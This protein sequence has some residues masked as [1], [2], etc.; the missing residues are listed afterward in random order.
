LKNNAL[1]DAAKKARLFDDLRRV[2]AVMPA[3]A[4]LIDV[5]ATYVSITPPAD[6]TRAN[7]E[8][9]VIACLRDALHSVIS[10]NGKIDPSRDA[11]KKFITALFHQAT[12]LLDMSVCVPDTDEEPGH[13]WVPFA[14]SLADYLDRFPSAQI[15]DTPCPQR[16]YIDD[17]LARVMVA[18]RVLPIS[19]ASVLS[20]PATRATSTTSSATDEAAE[21]A[22]L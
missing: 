12:K 7:S 15:V 2:L 11:E 9:L 13:C 21:A 19:W 18:A 3:L 1:I 14:E 10:P 17:A 22:A 16:T 5:F 8:P 6:P 20:A 4:D